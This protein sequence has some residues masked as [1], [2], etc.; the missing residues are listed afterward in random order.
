MKIKKG[1]KQAH[2]TGAQRHDT[3]GKG[4][5][6]LLPFRAVSE[7]AK[8]LEAG[9]AEGGYEARNWEKGIPLSRWLDSTLRHLGQA[10]I[11][12][13]DEPHWRAALWNLSCLIDTKMRIEEGLLPK[14]L[15][16]LIKEIG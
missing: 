9:I 5:F 2:T 3:A 1:N 10:A 4:R 14:E 16:D 6:D 13:V 11:G 8:H 7:L 12:M 15:D